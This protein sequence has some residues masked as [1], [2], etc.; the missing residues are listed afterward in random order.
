MY[1]DISLLWE[2]NA[3]TYYFNI[4]DNITLV[5]CTIHV[6][7]HFYL[8][9]YASAANG[10][11]DLHTYLRFYSSLNTLC[12]LFLILFAPQTTMAS[13]VI[14]VKYRLKI[15]ANALCSHRRV[16]IFMHDIAPFYKFKRT[17]TFLDCIEIH[18]LK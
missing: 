17:R 12:M 8:K 14:T 10:L 6:T 3:F 9:R 18:V 15:N 7:I 11:T 13:I 1:K 4:M 5:F 2:H 16:Y